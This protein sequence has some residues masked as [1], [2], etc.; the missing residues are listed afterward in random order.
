MALAFLAAFLW[1]VLHRATASSVISKVSNV[2]TIP[3]TA[4][5]SASSTSSSAFGEGYSGVL[6]CTF[7]TRSLSNYMVSDIC[8]CN[9]GESR[10]VAPYRAGSYK[11]CPT[12]PYTTT[13]TVTTIALAFQYTT[14]DMYGPDNAVIACEGISVAYWGVS[15]ETIVSRPVRAQQRL[16]SY[17]LI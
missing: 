9:N 1:Y 10:S 7:T 12:T 2:D 16:S 4:Q 5:P 15:S 8:T 11:L 13:S 3:V 6:S 17:G 14:V